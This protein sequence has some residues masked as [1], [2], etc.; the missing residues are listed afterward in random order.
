MVRENSYSHKKKKKGEDQSVFISIK[1]YDIEP[2]IV[3]RWSFQLALVG[4]LI[5][6][7][8]QDIE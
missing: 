1:G 3:T 5:H 4:K 2:T 6:F 8:M 7:P